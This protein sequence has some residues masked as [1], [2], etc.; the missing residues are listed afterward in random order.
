LI[1]SASLVGTKCENALSGTGVDPPPAL[2]V[3]PLPPPPPEPLPLVEL[4]RVVPLVDVVWPEDVPVLELVFVNTVELDPVVDA[5]ESAEL[6]LTLV[7]VAT[8]L[9]ALAVDSAEVEALA[10]ETPFVDDAV[11]NEL[12]APPPPAPAPD[13]DPAVFDAVAVTVPVVDD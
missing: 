9:L 4:A 8:P 7:V 13:E 3:L 11:N 5:L 6:G 2:L 1:D 10:D 12:V